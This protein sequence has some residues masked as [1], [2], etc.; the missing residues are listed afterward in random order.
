MNTIINYLGIDDSVICIVYIDKEH[1]LLNKD[2]YFNEIMHI[3]AKFIFN[4]IALI[5][6]SK[7]SSLIEFVS[8][9]FNN[10]Q[11]K[12]FT[13]YLELYLYTCKSIINTHFN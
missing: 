5:N 10:D 9:N 8:A 2:Q 6:N 11:K 13:D 12:Q 4:A 7:N 1:F 3:K